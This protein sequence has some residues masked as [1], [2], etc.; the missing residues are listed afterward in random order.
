MS[1]IASPLSPVGVHN[2][3]YD[4]LLDDGSGWQSDEGSMRRALVR[5]NSSVALD[6][7]RARHNSTNCT[8]FSSGS[9]GGDQTASSEELTTTRKLEV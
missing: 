2:T 7:L 3:E 4:V 1:L 6:G 5:K 8:P 9:G